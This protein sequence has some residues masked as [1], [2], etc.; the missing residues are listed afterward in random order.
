M[1][2]T[3]HN[4]RGLQFWSATQRRHQQFIINR[5]L[6]AGHTPSLKGDNPWA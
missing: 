4:F 3:T 2:W 1:S 6:L 5:G